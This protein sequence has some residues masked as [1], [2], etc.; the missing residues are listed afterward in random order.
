MIILRSEGVIMKNLL[1]KVRK[2]VEKLLLRLKLYFKK[3]LFPLYLFP[4]KIATY[5]L[6]YL[7]LFI[8][9]LIL[10]LLGLL[11]DALKYPFKSMKHFLKFALLLSAS[12]YLVASLFV[13]AD[14]LR[15]QYGFYGKFFCAYGTK[16]KLLSSVVRIVGG[17]SEGSGFFISETSVLTNFHVIA[18]EPS[19]KIIFP[20]GKFITPI[21]ILGDKNADLAVLIT[22]KKY[23]EKVL[24]IPSQVEFKADEPL[25]S[26]GYPLGTN[27]TGNA[28]V[29]R[30]NFIDFRHSKNNPVYYIQTNISLV[31]GM[32]GGPLTDQCG[33]VMGVNTM[34]L[35]GLSLFIGADQVKSMVSSFS[36]QGITKIEVDPSASPEDSVKAFY[37]YLK[38]RRMEDGFKL[39][40]QEYLK[41]TNFQEWTSR[42]KDI[43]DVNIIKS[44]K[45]ENSP[46]SA[47]IKFSTKNWID[48]EAEVHFYEG[49]WQ[50]VKEDR[51][52]KMLKSNIKEIYNP[53]YL[54]FYE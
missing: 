26:A 48:N 12:L 29:V 23:P 7:I 1:K 25:I 52:Y 5:S 28:T 13:I 8:I 42:F 45:L 46:D 15:I 38:A 20:D 24:S 27:L 9:K 44:E 41:K 54:W 17:Y 31:E 2:L 35:A 19:P 11:F 53:G 33:K 43:L 30:G 32:S 16:E 3:L 39:L 50:T 40:S 6:Y 47:F 37:T 21:K 18:D 10:A 4:L 49:T 22:D 51:V 36:D 34:S 14:Y